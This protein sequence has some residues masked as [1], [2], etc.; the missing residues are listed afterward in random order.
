MTLRKVPNLSVPQGLYLLND[1]NNITYFIQL[2]VVLFILK[3][4][5]KVKSVCYC[6]PSINVS[7]YYLDSVVKK[8]LSE[9]VTKT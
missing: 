8:V 9:E 3:N 2:L 6:K 4:T 7:C 5:D 1:D